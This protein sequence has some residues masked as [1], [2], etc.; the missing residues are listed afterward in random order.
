MKTGHYVQT[1]TGELVK[2]SDKPKRN[3]NYGR[4]G[5]VYFPEGG[6]YDRALRKYFGTKTQK[7]EYMRAHGLYQRDDGVPEKKLRSDLCEQ[8]N[9]DRKT[10]GLPSKTEAELCGDAMVR[11]EKGIM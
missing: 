8:I 9:I 5:P 2:V 6:Y 10:R 3:P 4:N 7:L 1:R 11:N